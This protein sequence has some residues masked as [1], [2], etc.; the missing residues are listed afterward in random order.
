MK[1]N[2]DYSP[3]PYIHSYGDVF[4][5][6][7]PDQR[8]AKE[9]LKSIEEKTKPLRWYPG[10][11]GRYVRKALFCITNGK[12]Y[13]TIKEAVDELGIPQYNFSKHLKG[14]KAYSHIGGFRFKEL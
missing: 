4:R 11:K 1:I 13:N 12:T 9:F 10:K 6:E 8:T 7:H 2:I 14:D 5:G 3:T